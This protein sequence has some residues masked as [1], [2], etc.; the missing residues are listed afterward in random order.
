MLIFRTYKLMTFQLS[1]CISN[2]RNDSKEKLGAVCT[3]GG[4]FLPVYVS[5]SWLF[6]R[7]M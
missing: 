3:L 4:R 1:V 2:A 7:S 6:N 5:T